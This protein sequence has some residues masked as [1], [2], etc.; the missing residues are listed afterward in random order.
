MKNKILV[1]ATALACISSCTVVN[2]SATNYID[3]DNET[4]TV[5]VDSV[6]T[7]ELENLK[8]DQS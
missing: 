5:S 1:F 6:P 8:M 2:V 7:I 3:D 4:M